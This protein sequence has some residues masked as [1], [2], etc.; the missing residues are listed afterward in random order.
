M[1][2]WIVKETVRSKLWP[3][4]S[5]VPQ[6]PYRP[7]TPPPLLSPPGLL[8]ALA[9]QVP[10]Q[11]ILHSLPSPSQ[12]FYE[13]WP[14]KF[15]NKTN[16][17]TQRRWLA[18]CNPDLRDLISDALGSNA[19]ISELDQLRGLRKHADD[20]KMQVWGLTGV[21]AVVGGSSSEL[22]SR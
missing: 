8:R 14:H 11:D 16:G 12:D 5:Q 20:E 13:L 3:H 7:S 2:R 17:V 21:V 4:K 19:W 10:E 18:F 1:T 15:Q 22:D 9:P 6:H